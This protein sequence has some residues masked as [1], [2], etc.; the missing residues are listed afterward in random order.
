VRLCVRVRVRVR[1]RHVSMR[2]VLS[3]LDI[4]AT[5]FDGMLNFADCLGRDIFFFGLLAGDFLL[6]S[7]YMVVFL[8][9]PSGRGFFYRK[10]G[11]FFI[12][13]STHVSR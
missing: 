9:W 2:T 10:A 7:M 13:S 8:L 5:T 1:M 6:Q 11:D 12:A 3:S 4:T